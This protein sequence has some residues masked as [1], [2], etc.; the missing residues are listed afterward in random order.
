MKVI[1]IEDQ[2]SNF[3]AILVSAIIVN[4]VYNIQHIAIENGVYSSG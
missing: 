3:L 4:N 1:L 2:E